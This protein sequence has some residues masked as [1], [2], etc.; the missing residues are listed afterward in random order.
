M[1]R[2]IPEDQD[3]KPIAGTELKVGFDGKKIMRA[4]Y[5]EKNAHTGIRTSKKHGTSKRTLM[6]IAL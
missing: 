3:D 1:I 6:L 2:D 5:E 4:T